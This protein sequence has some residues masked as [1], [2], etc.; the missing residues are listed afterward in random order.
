M[1]RRWSTFA[2]RRPRCGSRIDGSYKMGLHPRSGVSRLQELQGGNL[3]VPV[4]TVVDSVLCGS[5]AVNLVARVWLMSHELGGY[6][7]G[8]E[9]LAHM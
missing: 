5:G 1:R 2:L 8:K 3:R 6:I 9:D 4:L 7:L